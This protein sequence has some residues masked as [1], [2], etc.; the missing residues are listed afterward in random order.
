M[1]DDK[2]VATSDHELEAA[3]SFAADGT[4]A[5][6][7]NK[8]VVTTGMI[9][10]TEALGDLIWL[11]DLKIDWRLEYRDM[12]ATP[13]AQT[14]Y[15]ESK[16]RLYVT[17]GAAPG[18]FETVLYLGCSGAYGKRPANPGESLNPPD[19]N[20]NPNTTPV[21]V[22][23]AHNDEVVDA[24]WTKF[25]TG[26]GPASPKRV[27]GATLTYYGYRDDNANG[28]YDPGVDQNFNTTELCQNVSTATLLKEQNGQC[29]SW[30][31]LFHDV[32]QAQ[33][34]ESRYLQ[35]RAK[36]YDAGTDLA[37]N[38]WAK[39]GGPGPWLIV[40]VD[41]GVTGTNPTVVAPGQAADRL[42]TP[43][44]GSSP[45]PP[46]I[47]GKHFV[48][49]VQGRLFDPSY[50]VGNLRDYA[51]YEAIA[52]AGTITSEDTGGYLSLPPTNDHDSQTTTDLIATYDVVTF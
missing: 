4:E 13:V 1:G 29:F 34:V 26:N 52:F 23:W 41:A 31:N 25:S 16:N 39:S 22:G 17:G 12:Q 21:P 27:D 14:T 36:G 46:A 47:F 45:N 8:W 51:D 5:D 11:G 37:I 2:G 38:N 3:A 49:L 7:T 44:Q 40:S 9:T 32:L 33:D 24:I 35:I 6:G 20:D 28:T 48:T 18:E 42:G 19:P 43:G 10:S 15:G 50:G 30:A